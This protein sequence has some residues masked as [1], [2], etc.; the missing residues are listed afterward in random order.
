MVQD[1]RYASRLLAKKPAFTALILLTLALG[2][3]A[4]TAIFSVVDQVLLSPLPLPAP[5][6]L[7]RIQEQ[8]RHPA[9]L[10]GATFHDLQEHTRAIEHITAYRIFARNLTDVRQNSFPEQIDTA[11]VSPDFFAVAGQGPRI[12]HEF[13]LDQYGTNARPAL[14]LSDSLWRRM[15]SAD[16]K[17][18]G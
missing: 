5:E 10:T 1:F 2:V 13:T 9:N 16:P 17:I 4:N 15:F 14:M 7:L 8:H 11:L 18:V 6:A 12:G 3:G